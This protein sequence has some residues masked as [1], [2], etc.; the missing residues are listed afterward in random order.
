MEQ[1]SIEEL[2]NYDA[3]HKGD[4]S[5]SAYARYLQSKWR[6]RKGY[7]KQK[8]KL[9]NYLPVEFAKET[10]ANFLTNRI[11]NLVQSE[12]DK[13][14]VLGS[15][16]SEPRIWNNLLSSQPL[17]FNLFGE[18][19]FDLDLATKV[20]QALFPNKISKVTD[21]KFEYSPGRG[22]KNYTGD[23]SAFDAFIEYDNEKAQSE[24]I[25]IEVKYSE[26]M[27]QRREDSIKTYHKHKREY[28][29]IAKSAGI[30]P[31]SS[32]EILRESPLQQIWRDHLLS[33]ATEKD[34]SGGFFIFLHPE[35]NK[36]CHEAY[37]DYIQLLN[38]SD[39]DITK[40]YSITLEKFLDIL[41]KLNSSTWVIELRERYLGI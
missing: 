28:L 37:K 40:I 14:K 18:L 31:E 3:Y 33:L 13:S 17:C 20:F 32:I 9:G 27:R 21:V 41:F 11:G 24:Y 25:G 4:N 36:K 22:D 1:H 15:M 19:H 35:Q 39:P 34:Y 30:F 12:V 10:K 5:F 26:N 16:I 29:K 8:N 6:V 2:N 38:S 7:P 23:H